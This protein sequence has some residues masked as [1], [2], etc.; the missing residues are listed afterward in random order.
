[1]YNFS[2]LR[3]HFVVGIMAPYIDIEILYFPNILRIYFKTNSLK[4]LI[5][6]PTSSCKCK[7]YTTVYQ[8][9]SS[10]KHVIIFSYYLLNGFLVILCSQ[11]TSHTFLIPQSWIYIPFA[12]LW[13]CISLSASISLWPSPCANSL[14]I[15]RTKLI[16]HGEAEIGLRL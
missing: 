11:H 12:R 15:Q 14:G 4:H 8:V 10:M 16:D 1:M 7:S 3:Y 2:F 5:F 6:S 9:W 13:F